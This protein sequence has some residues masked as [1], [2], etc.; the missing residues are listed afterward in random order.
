M[1]K[2]KSEYSI[3][4]VLNALRLLEAFHD[5]PVLGVSELA[6]RLDLHKNN[7]FRLLAT[8]EQRRYIEQCAEKRY[9]L[10]PR[11]LELGRSFARSRTLLGTARPFLAGLAR[12]LG[13]S[14]H[15]GQLSQL[16]V[17]HLD[18]EQPRQ[19]VTTASRLGLRLPAHCTALGKALLG[20]APAERRAEYVRAL[21]ASGGP[22][23][24]TSATIVDSQKLVEHLGSVG[25]QGFAV[26]LDECEEG[27]RCAA[28]PV[29]DESGRLV[30]ALSV[31]GPSFRLSEERLFREVVPAVQA[32][33]EELSRKL[34][35][36][37]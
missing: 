17:V 15:L 6:R 28:A 35:F 18:G 9:C 4:T 32:A 23:A 33:A 3:Q 10:G 31:S 25:V 14:A 11:C 37:G 30:A 16:D 19:L 8:L 2:P 24:R 1:N 34:G 5:E 13:E 20:C 29:Q 7:V 27:L 26:D 12:E 21:A 36:A 22:A